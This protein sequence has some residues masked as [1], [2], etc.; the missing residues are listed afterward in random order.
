MSMVRSGAKALF[1]LV[2]RVVPS[3]AGP[4][5]LIYHQIGAGT[6]AQMDLSEGDFKWQME[7][8][9]ENRQVV[10][11]DQAISRWDEPGSEDLV[12]ITFDDGLPISPT[13]P[14]RFSS[15]L[16]FPSCSIWRL[17]SWGWMIGRDGAGPSIGIRSEI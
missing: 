12:V 2:D 5:I 15:S 16:V 3:R 4:R 6:G 11:L 1:S 14:C 13:R 8:L 17:R 7:W 9:A 10:S